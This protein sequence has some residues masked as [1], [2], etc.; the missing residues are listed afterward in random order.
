MA[1]YKKVYTRQDVKAMLGYKIQDGLL[2][3][4][5]LGSWNRGKFYPPIL[6]KDDWYE[7]KLG[8]TFYYKSA[9][10]KLQKYIDKKEIDLR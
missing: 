9:V 1:N 8:N 6:S 7:S 5:Q 10:T 3:K 4:L 2:S